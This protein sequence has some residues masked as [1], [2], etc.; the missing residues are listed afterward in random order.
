MSGHRSA[1]RRTARSCASCPA[2][3]M[4]G[5][6]SASRSGSRCTARSRARCPA[7]RRSSAKP[8]ATMCTARSLARCLTRSRSDVRRVARSIVGPYAK[9]GCGSYARTSCREHLQVVRGRHPDG[10]S[11]QVTDQICPGVGPQ[12]RL[13]MQG[14]DQV[15]Q[16]PHSRGRV[17]TISQLRTPS[18]REDQGQ[19]CQASAP[20]GP[21]TT[22]GNGCQSPGRLQADC[23]NQALPPGT[24]IQVLLEGRTR[25]AVVNAQEGLELAPDQFPSVVLGEPRCRLRGI[26]RYPPLRWAPLLGLLG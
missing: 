25:E 2:R 10:S 9:P 1:S 21:G 12:A 6:R 5:H 26:M 13:P 22:P 3:P 7:R 11:P 19:A 14:A 23:P 4:S 18:P 8:V 15:G 24:K 17:Q 20:M 16:V